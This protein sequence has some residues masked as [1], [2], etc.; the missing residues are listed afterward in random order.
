M[1]EQQE[2]LKAEDFTKENSPLKKVESK[3]EVEE[4]KEKESKNIFA[5]KTNEKTQ[6]EIK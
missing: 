3:E 5:D 4:L 1:K 6:Q 2:E